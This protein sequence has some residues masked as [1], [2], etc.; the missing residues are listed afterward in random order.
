MPSQLD[1][2]RYNMHYIYT[3][4]W[5]RRGDREATDPAFL[6]RT[7]PRRRALMGDFHRPDI[8]F[9]GD[10]YPPIPFDD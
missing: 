10:N 8:A 2:D 1:Y 4:P 6:A 3:P 9:S 5:M 7:T